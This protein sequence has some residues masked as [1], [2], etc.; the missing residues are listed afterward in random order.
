[1][2]ENVTV[3]DDANGV[4]TIR[5]DR[6][7][8]KNA[9]TLGMYTALAEALRGAGSATEIGVTVIAGCPGA[10][11][12]GNDLGDFLAAAAGGPDALAPILDFLQALVHARKPLVAAVDGVAVGVGATLLLHCDLVYASPASRFQFPFLNLGLVPEAA[13]TLLLPRLAGP[14]KA[15]ELLMLGEPFDAATAER[16]GLVNAVLPADALHGHAQAKAAALAAKPR[17]ALEAT[18]ALLRGDRPAVWDRVLKEAEVF[19]TCL[20]SPELKEAVT[21][22]REGRAPDFAKARTVP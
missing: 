5:I 11:S 4:R 10:F 8:K 16:L 2:H 9:L 1:M 21:A 20:R 17:M 3:V 15:A 22:F 13:S 12:A 14:A 18:R 7:E 6:P 19:G